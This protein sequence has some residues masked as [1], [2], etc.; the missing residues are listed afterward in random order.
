MRNCGSSFKQLSLAVF[1]CPF[2]VALTHPD[3]WTVAT[4]TQVAQRPDT[5]TGRK[6]MG[7]WTE[8]S[9][10]QFH[11]CPFQAR[12]PQ[13]IYHTYSSPTGRSWGLEIMHVKCTLRC[14][15]IRKS[16]YIIEVCICL[17]VPQ[18]PPHIKWEQWHIPHRWVGR[19]NESPFVVHEAALAHSECCESVVVITTQDP[20]PLLSLQAHSTLTLPPCLIRNQHTCFPSPSRSELTYILTDFPL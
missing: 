9:E 18:F 11:F 4:A 3:Q 19:L 12:G 15:H 10:S 17:W 14:R 2:Y 6:E 13:P 7:V 8:K 5:P 16:H 1:L 20:C